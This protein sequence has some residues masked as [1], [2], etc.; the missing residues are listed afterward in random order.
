MRSKVENILDKT[1]SV[2]KISSERKDTFFQCVAL[3][4]NYLDDIDIYKKLTCS[5]NKSS[6]YYR[7]KLRKELSEKISYE[8]N[9]PFDSF[10][11]EENIQIFE[12]KYNIQINIF[13]LLTK[14]FIYP[15][16]IRKML[17]VNR[18]V[19]FIRQDENI[20]HF[21]N[22]IKGA[23]NYNYF[24][25][26]CNKY[27][28]H[29]KCIIKK[30]D[31]IFSGGL[32]KRMLKVAC[33]NDIDKIIKDYNISCNYK[34][35]TKDNLNLNTD[36][37]TFFEYIH[38]INSRMAGIFIDFL[39]KR[40]ICELKENYFYDYH[41]MNKIIIIEQEDIFWREWNINFKDMYERVNNTYDHKCVDIIEDIFMISLSHPCPK[42]IDEI[43]IILYQIKINK[44]LIIKDLIPSIKNYFINREIVNNNFQIYYEGLEGTPD[45]ITNDTIIDIKMSNIDSPYIYRNYFFQLIGYYMLYS[46]SIDKNITKKIVIINYLKNYILTWEINWNIIDMKRFFTY[47]NPKRNY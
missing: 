20:Y 22:S 45:I 44:S 18:Q 34:L 14:K 13:D 43:N 6:I 12:N 1:F 17:L 26:K 21:C 11:M 47:I 28:K 36:I 23:L 27:G 10:V 32:L 40:I 19:Y 42:N 9:I 29:K 39:V 24:C 7:E 16:D 15:I 38:K 46:L 35:Y 30:P 31:V 37:I 4:I 5:K 2:K 33:S 8:I 25:I 41:M 3:G